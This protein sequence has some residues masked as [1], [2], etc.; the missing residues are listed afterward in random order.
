MTL[1]IHLMNYLKVVH[2]QELIVDASLQLDTH[3]AIFR[4]VAELAW[5]KSQA[6]MICL[7]GR[8]SLR[9]LGFSYPL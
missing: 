6:V 4:E 7:Q 9:M 1:V 8:V 2:L 3:V 5:P